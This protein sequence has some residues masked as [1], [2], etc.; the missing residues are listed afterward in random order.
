M[1]SIYI[2]NGVGIFILLL[3][4]YVSRART[5]RRGME[6]RL[7][8]AMLVGIM[9][10]CIM[11]M[12][13]YS[14]DGKLFFG[15]RFL[16]YAA[17]TYLFC[18][19]LLLPLG[20]LFYVDLG[21]YDDPRR[22]WKNYKPQIIIGAIMIALN[23]VNFFVPITYNITEQNVYERRPLCYLYYVVILYYL[24]TALFLTRRYERDYGTRAFFNITVFMIPILVGAGLQFAFY[25]LSLA[26]LASAIGLIGLFMMQQNEMAYIDALVD[27]YNRQYLNHVLSAWI[28]R[29]KSFAGIMFDADGFKGINDTYGHSEG[30]A[31][32]K[33]LADILKRSAEDG[34]LVFRFAGDE[35]IALKIADSADAMTP[36]LDNV[37]RNLEKFNRADRPYE[38]AVSYGVSFYD[39]GDLDAFVKEMD[40]GMYAM[41]AQHHRE[42]ASRSAD[43]SMAATA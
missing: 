29:G 31:A 39:S 3:L 28:A 32:L 24:A 38:L 7:F 11:E 9:I 18:A 19:N 36:Y 33:A 21:L 2:A 16:N 5:I 42:F 41:K 14:I 35:F 23:V 4:L 12:V 1:R 30:D 15:S 13:S 22:I 34:E 40:D 10:G 17:N 20:V 43:R 8:F 6:D 25:G 26:W 37:A 27:T